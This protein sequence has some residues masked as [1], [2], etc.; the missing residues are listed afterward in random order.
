MLQEAIEALLASKIGFD[1]T[2]IGSTKIDK[3]IETRRLACNL[4]DRESY[5]KRLETSPQELEDL[6]EELVVPETWFLRDRKPFEFLGNYV[7]SDWLL[8]RDNKSLRVLSAPCS[9]GEEPYSIAIALM[10][11]GLPAN[12]FGIDAIDISKRALSKAQQG[13]Y[14]KNSF[15]GGDIPQKERYFQETPEGM[16]IAPIIRQTVNFTHA[17][18]L[19]PFALTGKKYD[20]IFCRNLLIYLS[21]AASSQVME[22]LDRLLLPN[23]LLFVG[24]S[25]MGKV[26]AAKFTSLRQPFTFAYRKKE[27]NSS[28]QTESKLPSFAKEVESKPQNQGRESIREVLPDRNKLLKTT[29]ELLSSTQNV[30]NLLNSNG[31]KPLPNQ[32]YNS[33]IGNSEGA[34]AQP[35]ALIPNL[36]TAIKLA[37]A[38]K[39]E[40]AARIGKAYLQTNPTSAQAYLLL[41][42][43][44][45]ASGDDRQAEQ[46]F[47]KAVYLEPNCYEALT[48]LALLKRNRGDI[49]SATAIE[50]RLQRLQNQEST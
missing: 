49:R 7:I 40:E 15:R 17:N 14:G 12:L 8:K 30:K 28:S 41:G 31:T 13:I 29:K 34:I 37:D 21:N 9:T 16:E 26:P 44:S 10:N 27:Q 6:I 36:Q 18:L 5:L 50:Q 23:G 25:E 47:Q 32:K 22:V 19:E 43:V 48:H 45:Q 11:A 42:E 20:I 33:N 24:A 46:Y 38:G 3:I 39:L 2:T 4:T 35:P 1:L